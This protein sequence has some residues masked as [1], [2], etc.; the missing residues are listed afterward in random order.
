MALKYAATCSRNLRIQASRDAARI[1]RCTF[2]RAT[3]GPTNTATIATISDGTLMISGIP[4][5]EVAVIGTAPWVIRRSSADWDGAPK[6]EPYI[7]YAV[8]A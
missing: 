8:L 7:F 3:K 5:D 1:C 6:L 2:D 4:P